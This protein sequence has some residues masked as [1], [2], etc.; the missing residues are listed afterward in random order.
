MGVDVSCGCLCHVPLEKLA[1][2]RLARI[3]Q[4]EIDML[5]RRLDNTP[6]QSARA[7]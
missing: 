4:R 5:E 3:A 7:N 2:H 1:M 6:G